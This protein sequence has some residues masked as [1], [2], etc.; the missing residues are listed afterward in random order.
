MFD[1]M[2]TDFRFR[3]TVKAMGGPMKV[4]HTIDRRY[5]EEV[6][7]GMLAKFSR[8]ST[9]SEGI[10]TD[11]NSTHQTADGWLDWNAS[12]VTRRH[13]CHNDENDYRGDLLAPRDSAAAANYQALAANKLRQ[14]QGEI[15]ALCTHS[16]EIQQ[17]R[18]KMG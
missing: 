12:S 1:Q 14:L 9:G 15:L 13:S 2:H 17:I 8:E 16:D 4:S 6:N 5:T 11:G 3:E 7:K 18:R 10:G